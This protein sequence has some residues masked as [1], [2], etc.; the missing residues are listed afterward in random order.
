MKKLFLLTVFGLISYI[1]GPLPIS[2]AV[3]ERIAAIVNQEIITFSEIEKSMALL[4]EEIKVVDRLEKKERIND[5]SRKI[6]ERLVEEKL[7]DQEAK[8]AGLKATDKEVDGA[9]EEIRKRNNLT[10]EELN[11]VLENEGLTM[12]KF[13]EQLA[14]RIQRVKLINMAVKV[15]PNLGDKELREFYERNINRYRTAETFRISHILFSIPKEANAE[16]VEEIKRKCRD[17]LKKIKGGEDFGEMALLYSDDPSKMEKGDLGFFKKGELLPAL[18]KEAIRLKV[19]E[20]SGIIRT[21][22]GFHIIKLL[23]RKGG[24]S[25]PFDEIKNR[26]QVDYYNE[27]FEK[28]VRQYINKLREKSVIEIKL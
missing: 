17:V 6:L 28:A 4:K 26:V 14:K 7:L 18:E 24:D 23:E 13:R 16:K 12:E 20:V 19:G 21:D 2:Y 3:V 22:F 27:E 15:E 5:L 25:P 11:K 10:N 8:K 1:S 9:V